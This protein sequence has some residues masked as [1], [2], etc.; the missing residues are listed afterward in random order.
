MQFRNRLPS[1]LWYISIPF[2]LLGLAHPGS[3][4]ELAVL[5]GRGSTA[6]EMLQQPMNAAVQISIPVVRELRIGVAYRQRWEEGRNPGQICDTYWRDYTGCTNEGVA[7][8]SRLTQWEAGFALG[9]LIGPIDVSLGL[10]RVRTSLKSSSMGAESGR[11]SDNYH[12]DE[13]VWGNAFLARARWTPRPDRHVG[14]IAQFR[15]QDLR[16]HG[17][18]M[19]VGTP[20]CGKHGL[21][22]WEIGVALHR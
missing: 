11:R 14:I 1:G 18:V 20:F 13:I 5:V 10:N 15:H 8:D 9:G 4:Q 12:E 16:F 21:S 17:C 3:A 6:F 19:D 7:Y 22:S 2:L